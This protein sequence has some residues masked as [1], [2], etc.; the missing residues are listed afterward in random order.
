[1]GLD[2]LSPAQWFEQLPQRYPQ[3]DAGALQQHVQGFGLSPHLHK[4][5]FQLS[6]GTQRKV[7]LAAGLASGA[8][9][10]LFDEPIAG[11]DKPSILYLQQALAH[12]AMQ[13][14]RAFV[15]AHYEPLP[16]VP[17][18]DTWVLPD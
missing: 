6:T 7:L 1:A 14:R 3:W 9:L 5:M 16:G 18:R 12:Q 11:L 8:E 15:V 10:T 2:A 4:P 13:P 17:W